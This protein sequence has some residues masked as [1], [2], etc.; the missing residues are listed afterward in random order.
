MIGI[1]PSRIICKCFEHN[2]EFAAIE[3]LEEDEK[4]SGRK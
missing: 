4:A 2:N 3:K 1:N